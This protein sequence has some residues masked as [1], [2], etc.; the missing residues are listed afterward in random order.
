M[1]ALN[2]TQTSVSLYCHDMRK[3]YENLDSKAKIILTVIFASLAVL[4]VLI[5]SLVVFCIHRTKQLDVQSI[6]LFHNSSII[7][8]LNSMT[9]FVHL[10]AILDPYETGCIFHYSLTCMLKFAIY[11]SRFM[12]PIT[13]IDRFI[14]IKYHNNYSSIFTPLRFKMIHVVYFICTVYQ[15]SIA[16]VL[17]ALKVDLT[18]LKFTLPLNVVTAL[19]S[20]FLY[21]KSIHLLQ[22]HVDTT[23]ISTSQRSI[24]KITSMYFYAYVFNMMIFL[25]QPFLVKMI[26]Y[27][28]G[29]DSS[30]LSVQLLVFHVTP[31]AIGIVNAF[32]FLKINRKC[33]GLLK[34]FLRFNDDAVSTISILVS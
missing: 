11:S 9:N 33:C 34:S 28:A 7:T 24:V 30:A 29:P 19:G 17:V 23:T 22:R 12:V 6:R 25:A 16:T 31:T 2:H 3:V 4:G 26:H 13:A 14:H 15:S 10:K 27:I 1:P 21:L 20:I 5:N 32:A 8:I 18:S